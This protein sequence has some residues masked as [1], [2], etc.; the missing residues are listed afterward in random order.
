MPPLVSYH[1][2]VSLGHQ[3]APHLPFLRRYARALT[4]SQDVGDQL[5]KSTLRLIVEAP[6]VFPRDVDPR[7]GLYKVLQ[8]ELQSFELVPASQTESATAE[9]IAQARLARISP[10]TRQALLLTGMEGFSPED[11]AYLLDISLVR[12]ESLV[13]QALNELK[14]QARTSIL[15]I[16]NDPSIVS[17]IVEAAESLGHQVAGVAQTREEA[18]A[19]FKSSETGIVTADIRLV[20]GSSGIEAV[21]DI[22]R[23]RSVPVLFVTADPEDLLTGERPEPTYLVTKPFMRSTLQ[24]AINQALF[25]NPDTLG[26]RVDPAVEEQTAEPD[27]ELLETKAVRAEL[28]SADLTPRPGPRK[29]AVV[30]DRIRVIEADPEYAVAL[31]GANAARSIHLATVSRLVSD[32]SGGNLSP[33]ALARMSALKACLEQEVTE[34]RAIELGIQTRSLSKMLPLI[35]SEVL[36]G[37]FEDIRVLC[38]DLTELSWQ[39]QS[40]RDFLREAGSVEAIDPGTKAALIE[41]AS[42]IQNTEESYVDD[43]AKEAISEARELAESTDDPVWYFALA[44]EIGNFFRAYGR[45]LQERKT[46]IFS[47][48]HQAFDKVSGGFIGAMAAVVFVVGPTLYLLSTAWPNEFAFAVSLAKTVKLLI[49]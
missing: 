14:R 20:D 38:S 36:E 24:A 45:Y 26:Q 33:G 31:A 5:V 10:E 46:Q 43:S 37:T 13:A 35:E 1:G 32:L 11:A 15:V 42:V 29:M 17:Q 4:G 47:N 7:L 34:S 21:K 19:L 6:N 49:P 3:I 48:A 9:G 18:V 25:Y 22:L 23:I 2:D 16:E 8:K 41:A 40:F 27:S 44:R 28:A 30:Q 39:F 12:V